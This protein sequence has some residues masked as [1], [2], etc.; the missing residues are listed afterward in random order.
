MPK[1]IPIN[2][3]FNQC[4]STSDFLIWCLTF[5]PFRIPFPISMSNLCHTNHNKSTEVRSRLPRMRLIESGYKACI[6]D[7]TYISILT[8]TQHI[9]H[10][11]FWVRSMY[12][13]FDR[14]W[15]EYKDMNIA[16]YIQKETKT[17]YGPVKCMQFLSHKKVYIINENPLR[18]YD[19]LFDNTWSRI[20][21]WHCENF[22]LRR[23]V[24]KTG[25]N[26]ES[27]AHH[28]LR[29]TTHVGIK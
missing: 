11:Q 25:E 12:E 21:H 13:K 8:P 10:N 16:I 29:D 7:T 6:N 22:A 19:F 1:P 27:N 15:M 5:Y 4:K 14:Y 23:L 17:T 2:R 18:H 20:S 26:V 3:T 24:R 9:L 28:W